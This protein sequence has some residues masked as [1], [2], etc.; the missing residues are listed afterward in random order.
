MKQFS[1]RKTK[2]KYLAIVGGKLK[3]DQAKL[4]WPIARN[5]NNPSLFKV[6][7]S[8]KSSQTNYRIIDSNVEDSLS[9][10]ELNPITGRTHQLRVHMAHLGNIIIGD[11]FYGGLL[12]ETRLMLHAYSLEIT[13]PGGIRKIFKADPPDDFVEF[14]NIKK[15]NLSKMKMYNE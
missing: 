14:C 7:A 10:L 12:Q 9:L 4:D 13:I 1:E 15:L 3:Y 8:G 6:L 2:K 11:R 5:K